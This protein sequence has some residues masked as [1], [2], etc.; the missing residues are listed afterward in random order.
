MINHPGFKKPCRV[1]DLIVSKDGGIEFVPQCQT[2]L[3]VR[4]LS[5]QIKIF[6]MQKG[7]WLLFPDAKPIKLKRRNSYVIR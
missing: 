1:I 4:I 5:A 6:M 2:F 3:Y 7:I